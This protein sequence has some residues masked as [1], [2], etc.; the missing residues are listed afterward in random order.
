MTEKNGHLTVKDADLDE[1]LYEGDFKVSA[2]RSEVIARLP[3][4]YSEEKILIFEWEADGERGI[5]HYLCGNP[6]VSLEK[7][8]EIMEKYGL[9]G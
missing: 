4:Y 1:I 3:V 5:N 2:N 9:W 6:P 7:Y 8:A